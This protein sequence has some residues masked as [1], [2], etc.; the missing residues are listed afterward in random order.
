VDAR[1]D[2]TGAILN[3][4]LRT[5]P[6]QQQLSLAQLAVFPSGFDELGAAAVLGWDEQRA[7]GLLQVLYRHGLVSRWVFVQ[8]WHCVFQVECWPRNW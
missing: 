6:Q 2:E 4:N 7:R 3:L 8:I 5:L 1:G